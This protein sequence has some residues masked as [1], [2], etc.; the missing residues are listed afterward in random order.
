[1]R[2]VEMKFRFFAV[3][4]VLALLF[5]WG[6]PQV[7]LNKT[8]FL[9][10]ET[11]EVHYVSGGLTKQGAWVGIIPSNIPHGNESVND[12]N[13]V[14]YQYTQDPQGTVQLPAPLKSGSYDMRLN[15]G[16]GKELASATF[17]VEAVD[18]KATI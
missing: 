7:K 13:D 18:Y 3:V 16:D 11:I 5:A 17:Q 6:Q 10:G 15:S 9:P 2:E 1:M 12:Q 8:S 4:F 14:A